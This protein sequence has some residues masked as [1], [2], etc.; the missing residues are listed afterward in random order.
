MM[1]QGCEY[2]IFCYKRIIKFVHA[3]IHVQMLLSS[4]IFI[5]GLLDYLLST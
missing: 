2:T 3:L 5:L 4:W 1:S